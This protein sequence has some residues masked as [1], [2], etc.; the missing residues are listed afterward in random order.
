M[1]QFLKVVAFM[2]VTVGLFAGY[3]NLGIPQIQPA[4]PP[5]E[6]K[7]DLSA[8]T[9]DQFVALGE[10]LFSGKGTCTLCH[11]ALGRAPELGEIA[12]SSQARLDDPRYAGSA[13][14]IEGY[15]RESLVDPSAFVVV[16]FGKAGSNDTESPM[17][18]VNSGSIGMSDPE[19]AAVIA[20]L[21][22]N[23]GLEITV[24]IPTDLGEAEDEGEATNSG[25]PREPI[26]D[27][28]EL[29]D[30]HACEACHTITDAAG[31]I[32]PDLSKIG[33]T[34]DRDYI[35]QALLDPNAVIAE[36]YEEGF[37]PDDL[38]Q[39]MYATEL[40]IMVDFLSNLK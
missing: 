13:S 36:G 8:M 30:N 28:Q 11:N 29:V 26:T 15:I 2:V 21:Q 16:G 34:Q 18:S 1:R 5:T 7:I 40:E 31:D 24:E 12:I 37:M 25:E 22:D 27:I 4:P 35:R 19:T 33:A 38:G 10:R 32:G 17:P 9:M 3:S 6:E 14:D 39:Q 20:Y 23:G